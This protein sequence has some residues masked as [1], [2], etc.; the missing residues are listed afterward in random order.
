[1]KTKRTTTIVITIVILLIGFVIS[2]ITN[3][4]FGI[5]VVLAFF[6]QGLRRIENDPPHKGIVTILGKRQYKERNGEKI[7]VY[8]N[9]GWR[10]FPFCPFV[11]NYVPVNV[12]RKLFEIKTTTRTPD[13]AQVEITISITSRPVPEYLIQYE[14]SGGFEGVKGHLGGEIE[15]R[16]REWAEGLQEGPMDWREI[17]QAKLEAAS[18]LI[19]R[20]A[21]NGL[22]KI[23]TEEAQK[24]PTYIL[25]RYYSKP[26][27]EILGEIE[28]K[29][30]AKFKVAENEIP[31]VEHNWKKVEDI[32]NEIGPEESKERKE[33]EIAVVSRK[34]QI[35]KIRSGEGR[36]DM[37]DVGMRLERLNIS[38][39]EVTGEAGKVADQ[40]A[41]EQEELQ[42]EALEVGHLLKQLERL[43]ETGYSPEQALEILQTER[44]KVNKSIDEKKLNISPES[45]QLFEKLGKET[46]DMILNKKG[47]K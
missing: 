18:I 1:M 19:K 43:K 2:V 24:I 42:A 39:V 12:E 9:E 34:E 8:A 27:I 44:G 35:R 41:K 11:V 7:T 15:E 23:P 6:A 4:F 20:V 45:R 31:W 10:F 33:V 5:A 3:L 29:D 30:K 22:I 28:I 38:N 37:I 36:V 47:G 21:G 13:R 16:I 40:Q 26:R 46:L 17:Y 32:L 14:D 25:L